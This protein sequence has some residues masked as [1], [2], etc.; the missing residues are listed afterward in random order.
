MCLDPKVKPQHE[1]QN[2]PLLTSQQL[3]QEDC[4][5]LMRFEQTLNPIDNPQYLDPS[6]NSPKLDSIEETEVTALED[7]GAKQQIT[8]DLSD[9]QSVI[10]VCVYD[11]VCS[12]WMENDE[13]KICMICGKQFR[14]WRPRHVSSRRVI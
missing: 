12:R 5:Q 3:I 4:R 1:Y 6:P 7:I 13:S 10:S 14:L 8:P 11:G 9:H 2:E